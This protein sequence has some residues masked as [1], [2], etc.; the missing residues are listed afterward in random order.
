MM[1]QWAVYVCCVPPMVGTDMFDPGGWRGGVSAGDPNR[2]MAAWQTLAT[3]PTVVFNVWNSQ[4]QLHLKTAGYSSDTH[5]SWIFLGLGRGWWRGWG[6]WMEVPSS[7]R[8]HQLSQWNIFGPPWGTLCWTLKGSHSDLIPRARVRLWVAMFLWTLT[9]RLQNHCSCP[10]IVYGFDMFWWDWQCYNTINKKTQ[11]KKCCQSWSLAFRAPGT[12]NLPNWKNAWR[13][14]RHCCGGW[15]GNLRPQEVHVNRLRHVQNWRCFLY[16]KFIYS[17]LRPCD[18]DPVLHHYIKWIKW[19]WIFCDM[20]KFNKI[21]NVSTVR[22][23]IF[24]RWWK[25]WSAARVLTRQGSLPEI[26]TFFGTYVWE[27]QT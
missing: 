8:S 13:K 18:N 11:L 21:R 27:I 1:S 17:L 23:E 12:T 22:I 3:S 2:A 25:C 10:E 4:N 26:A 19:I 20:L 9:S 16:L 14:G 6:G 24:P 5:Q 15:A 7:D